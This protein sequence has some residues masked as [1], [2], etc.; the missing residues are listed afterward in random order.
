[1]IN[2]K[3]IFAGY[4]MFRGT[5]QMHLPLVILMFVCI[6]RPDSDN[7]NFTGG[8]FWWW[9]AF[10]MHIILGSLHYFTLFGFPPG[11]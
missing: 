5:L 9:M 1:M 6:D 10:T 3:N 8:L 4:I 2:L 7:D 11:F